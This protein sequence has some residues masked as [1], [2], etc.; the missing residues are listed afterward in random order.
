MRRNAAH[1]KRI[2]SKMKLTQ[3]VFRTVA[4]SLLLT[5]VVAQAQITGTVTDKTTSKPAV[6][7]TVVL[8][9][10]Q[11]GMGEVAKDNHRRRR[12]LQANQARP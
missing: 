10:V 5:G 4:L 3:I 9:D 6:G 12:T 2:F 11:T 8:V 1:I 7:D